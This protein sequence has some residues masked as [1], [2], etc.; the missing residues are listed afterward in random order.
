MDICVVHVG[1][2]KYADKSGLSV[3]KQFTNMNQTHAVKL[4]VRKILTRLA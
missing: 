1:S 2:L 3:Y 4:C